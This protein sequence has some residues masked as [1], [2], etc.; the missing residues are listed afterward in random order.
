VKVLFDTNVLVAAFITEG[1]CNKLLH[2]TAKHH[3]LICSSELLIEFAETLRNKFEYP[4]KDIENATRSLRTIMSFVV[5]AAWPR[6]VSRDPDDDAV[7]LTA[8]AG[9]CDR[10]VSG[11]KDLLDLQSFEGIIICTP[12]AFW[13]ELEVGK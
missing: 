3:D 7:L 8:L 6:Q 5:P 13:D 11:D 10:I 4:E 12:R 1:F 2:Y 9:Q